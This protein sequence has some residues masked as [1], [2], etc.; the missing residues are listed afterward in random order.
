MANKDSKSFAL[1]LG[2]M[3]SLLHALAR[4][5]FANARNVRNCYLYNTVYCSAVSK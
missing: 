5:L 4:F 2:E 1:E 3:K